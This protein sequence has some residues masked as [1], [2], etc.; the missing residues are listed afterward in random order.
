M[1]S[2][3]SEPDAPEAP[4]ASE[5]SDTSHYS[6]RLYI[7]GQTPKSVAAIRNLNI[8]CETH[9]AGRYTIEIKHD[10][11]RRPLTFDTSPN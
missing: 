6:L 4:D 7:A 11:T 1:T 3:T 5:G 9:L 2:S 10:R 8:L